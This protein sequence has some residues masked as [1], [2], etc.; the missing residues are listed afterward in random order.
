MNTETLHIPTVI[1]QLELKALNSHKTMLEAA[2]ALGISDKTLRT[3]MENNNVV[4]DKRLRQYIQKPKTIIRLYGENPNVQ[5]RSVS[6]GRADRAT[7]AKPAGA[8]ATA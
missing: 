2:T 3:H 6:H 1:L 8:C 7:E 5:E 4:W